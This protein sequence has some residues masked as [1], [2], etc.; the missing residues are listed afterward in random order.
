VSGSASQMGLLGNGYWEGPEGLSS[1]KEGDRAHSGS[2]DREVVGNPEQQDFCP[3]LPQYP[4][5]SAWLLHTT[6]HSC[7]P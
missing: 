3:Q 1:K 2:M 7:T 4:G 6:G 5:L